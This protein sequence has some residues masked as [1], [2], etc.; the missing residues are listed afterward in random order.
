M[1]ILPTRHDEALHYAILAIK[2]LIHEIKGR[3]I[4]LLLIFSDSGYFNCRDN[5]G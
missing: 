1:Y 2:H 3:L 5:F 4:Q